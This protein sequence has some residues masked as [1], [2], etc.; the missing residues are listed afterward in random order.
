MNTETRAYGLQSDN[1]TFLRLNTRSLR[2]SFAA[3][4]VPTLLAGCTSTDPTA[5]TGTQQTG[6][7]TADNDAVSGAETVIIGT[8]NFPESEII[9]QL[10]AEAL[11]ENG[12]NVEVTSGIGAREV[13][14]TA[15][16]EGSVTV[17][18]EYAGNLAQF[19]GE[20]P[21]GTTEE[22]VRQTLDR[23]LPDGLKVG[24][25]ARAESKDA[26]RVTREVAQQHNLVS[27]G[28]LSNLDAITI[29]A[30]PEFAERPYGPEGL[31]EAYGVDA[32]KIT[33]TP[34]SDGGGPLTVAALVEGDA[35]VANIYTTSP[36]LL[37][38]GDQ[39]DLVIL[40]DPEGLIPAQN[41][42][43]L[44]RAS[45]LPSGALDVI[46][47]INATLT[48]DDLVAMNLRN[49]GPERAEP[50]QIAEDYLAERGERGQTVP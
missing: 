21:A 9:G 47:D 15:L 6:K 5:N 37:S 3:L 22:G 35:N 34:I 29:A 46:N 44:Y 49:V 45:A 20:L 11:R 24:E 32:G 48:T 25:F 17:V 10:W 12:F 8:A 42:V 28:D 23:N 16:E 4:A 36:A 14:V 40:E 38:N 27:I 41:V 19:V 30:P 31:S 39:A 2:L 26:Y 43:P 7:T 13:Y 18:P 33:L 1:M 50:Q